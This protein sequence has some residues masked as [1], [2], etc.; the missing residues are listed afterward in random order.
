MGEI[1]LVPTEGIKQKVIPPDHPF[2]Y[3]SLVET[4]NFQGFHILGRN[5]EL[6]IRGEVGFKK[7]KM[8]RI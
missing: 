2:L 5:S 4:L 6:P 3:Q 8:R 1:R 7:F